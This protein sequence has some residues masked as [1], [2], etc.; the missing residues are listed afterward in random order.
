VGSNARSQQ[1]LE[2]GEDDKEEDQRSA[3]PLGVLEVTGE[4]VALPVALVP[5]EPA[6]RQLESAG[7]R[8]K[9]LRVGVVGPHAPRVVLLALDPATQLLLAAER[10]SAGGG[11]GPV[12]EWRRGVAERVW[13]SASVVLAPRL[14]LGQ[15]AVRLADLHEALVRR[16]LAR[17]RAVRPGSSPT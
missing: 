4:P 6:E 12:P 7:R 10:V 2:Q 8:P 9:R 13:R 5:T 1:E 3:Q 16:L 15:H 11:A 17:R 14:L